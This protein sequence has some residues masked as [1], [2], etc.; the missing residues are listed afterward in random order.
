MLQPAA[1]LAALVEERPRAADLTALLPPGFAAATGGGGGVTGLLLA[2]FGV[3]M[4]SGSAMD[5]SSSSS[6]SSSGSS[7]S[8]DLSQT[9]LRA[10]V[11]AAVRWQVSTG[12]GGSVDAH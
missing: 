1:T 8:V 9:P 4:A 11:L 6:N 3:A 2:P 10:G 5:G 7:T 12:R